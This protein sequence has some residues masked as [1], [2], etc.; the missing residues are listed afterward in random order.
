MSAE[1]KLKLIEK[2]ASTEDS[3]LLK[4]I[5]NLI[6]IANDDE[7]YQL[8]ENQ[9]SD[10]AV[11]EEQIKYGEMLSNEEAKNETAKWLDK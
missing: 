9:L 2:I 6:E 3:I 10:I 11:A 5:G 8:S 4:E 1:E 7:T